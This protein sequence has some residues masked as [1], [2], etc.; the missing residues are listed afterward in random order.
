MS[1]T[2]DQQHDGRV[3]RL[4]ELM[5]C[6]SLAIDLGL[7][8]PLEWVMRTCLLGVRLA[9][10]LGLSIEEQRQVYYLSL[11]R[12]IG[13]TA[14]ATWEAAV[15][16]DEL[17]LGEALLTD[18]KQPTEAI[19][20]LL[21]TPGK[22]QPFLTRLRYL[23]KAL[24]AGPAMKD[25]VDR[26]QCE[27][28]GMLASRLGFAV[29][30]RHCLGQI[31]E[32]W[33]GQ[34]IP[35]GLAREELALPVRVAHLAHDAATMMQ[36]AEAAIELVR[37]RSDQLYDPAIVTAFCRAASQLLGPLPTGSTWESILAAEPGPAV[38]LPETEMDNALSV[39]ADFVDLKAPL[40]A[41]HSRAVAEL[42][43]A[44][45]SKCH[46]PTTD[47][48][49]LRRAGL[50]HDLGKVGISAAIWNKP[51]P[52]TE[53]E[54]E[55][56]RLHPYLTERILTRSAA[57]AEPLALAVLHHERLDGSGY[58][59]GLSEMAQSLSARILAAANVYQA[60]ISPRPY[61]STFSPEAA[62]DILRQEVKNGRLDK[63]AVAAVLAVADHRVSMSLLPPDTTL[64]TREIEV[65][66]LLVRGL[67]NKEI[68]AKLIISPKTVGHHVQHIY[69]KIGVSSRAAATLY[70]VENNL[71]GQ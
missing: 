40:F 31:F 23:G 44:A 11:L 33:D 50:I 68:A 12:H 28:A 54:W 10:L 5:A 13:C 52:L 53:G 59:R 58:H 1:T 16:G 36:G 62:A 32:R 3:L 8:Q 43:A 27:V 47:I 39:I 22:G 18:A 60:L 67:T 17:A 37:K 20:F 56:V 70:A 26:I 34:G 69:N 25:A 24:A 65:L 15:F 2:F 9:E 19:R 42:A 46:L 6:F 4:A 64:S 7:G 30:I 49:V 14:T 63:M 45:G 55:R 71:L 51:G 57:F 38:W 61:R 29:E 66:R 35:E 48:V 21:T 41:G